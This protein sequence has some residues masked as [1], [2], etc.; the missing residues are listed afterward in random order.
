MAVIIDG[1][2]VITRRD[3]IERKFPGGWDAFLEFVP[4]R[5]IC[6]DQD[7][8]RAT[9]MRAEDA[10]EFLNRMIGQHLEFMRG[11]EC[12]DISII[13]QAGSL[14]RNTPWLTLAT[15]NHPRIGGE[16]RTAS[17]VGSADTGVAAPE[18][19][20]Y[21]KSLYANLMVDLKDLKYLRRDGNVDVYWHPDRK[22]EIYVGVVYPSVPSAARTEQPPAE[23]A[24]DPR[25]RATATRPWWSHAIANIRAWLGRTS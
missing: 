5:Q 11:D 23:P 21:E 20:R 4:T 2:C 17:M 6:W 25:V 3:A 10:T 18:G 7:I 9:F 22:E 16:V 15:L 14:K 1:F 24:A 12:I 13:S 8:V 19:W